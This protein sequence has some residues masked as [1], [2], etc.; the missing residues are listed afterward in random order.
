MDGR[1]GVGADRLRHLMHRSCNCLVAILLS[2]SFF[3]PLLMCVPNRLDGA[4]ERSSSPSAISTPSFFSH[5]WKMIDLSIKQASFSSSSCFVLCF[6]FEFRAQF[7]V[8]LAAHCTRH[9][10]VAQIPESI[11]QTQRVTDCINK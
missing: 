9:R 7:D 1:G 2:L 3:S 5:P 8:T 6:L 4:R 11:T 10:L